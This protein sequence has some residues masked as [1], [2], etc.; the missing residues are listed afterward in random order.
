[1]DSN[2]KIYDAYVNRVESARIDEK[3]LYAMVYE[4]S[5]INENG[6]TSIGNIYERMVIAE[7]TD[8]KSP[9][10]LSEAYDQ[11]QHIPDEMFNVEE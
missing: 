9:I 10:T 1:M 4:E 11:V 6:Q 7:M 2:S 5:T 8:H 3:D